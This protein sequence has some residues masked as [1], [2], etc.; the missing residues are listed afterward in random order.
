MVRSSHEACDTANT[1]SRSNEKVIMKAIY[2]E[3]FG[4][5]EV[6]KFGEMPEPSLVRVN[7]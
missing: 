5:R 1:V 2:F 4:G 3:A 7:C 6:L